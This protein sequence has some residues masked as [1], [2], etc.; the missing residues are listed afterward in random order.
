M[1]SAVSHPTLWRTCRVLA[2]ETRLNL[3][4]RLAS[5][6][7]QCVSELAAGCSL[8]LPVASQSL[9]ALE[10]RGFLQANRIR[11]RVEYRIP[12]LAEAGALRE[13]LAAL[14]PLLRKQPVPVGLIIKLA[15]AFTHP[16]RIQIHRELHSGAKTD[17]EL[18]R[19]I[20]LSGMA[21]WRHLRKLK[22]R[23]FI[24]CDEQQHSYQ[25]SNPASALG[26]ALGKLANG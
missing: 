10:S 13:L 23:G 14:L 15:T 7:P 22:A 5:R 3:L 20:R 4:A 11:R 1:P 24:V 16:V 12:P 21:R 17:A 2:N 6:Q 26:K 25:P 19:T 8:T 9:R 18:Q